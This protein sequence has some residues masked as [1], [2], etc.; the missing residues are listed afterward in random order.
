MAL[1]APPVEII[2]RTLPF[3]V[4][5]L[6]RLAGIELTDLDS[7]R[8]SSWY[9]DSVSNMRARGLPDSQHLLG[10]ALDVDGDP[11]HLQLFAE[12]SRSAGLVAILSQSHVHLQLLPA[13]RARGLGLFDD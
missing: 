12:R 10:L 2:V 5:F 6:N 8:V 7:L 9:R 1:V 13:G 11:L 3:F 4:G